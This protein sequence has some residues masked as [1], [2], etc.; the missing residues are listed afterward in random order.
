MPGGRFPLPSVLDWNRWQFEP[1][2][3]VGLL[4]L[5][6]AYVLAATRYRARLL[7]LGGPPPRW[8]PPG[9]LGPERPGA[10]S[11]WQ[12]AAFFTATLVTALALLSPL[13]VLG[14]RYLLSAHMVQHLLLT[15]VVPPLWLMG[16]PGWMLRPL[17]RIRFVRRA[18]ASLLTPLPAFFLF[19]AVFLVWH[20]PPFYELALA[21]EPVHVLEH[22]SFLALGLLTWWPVVGPLPEFP[23]LPYG[24]QVLYLFFESLPPT[25]LGALISLAEIP[26]YPTY[27]SAP[28]ITPLSPL[29]DQQLGG[30]IM[31]LPGALAYFVA[32]SIVFFLWLERQEAAREAPYGRTNPNRA[33]REHGSNQAAIR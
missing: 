28:R 31:W 29:E 33:K 13:H 4:A 1:G 9:S 8:H 32:L 17:L 12:A 6:A 20:A 5:T 3:I 7:A 15:L 10:L 30:L 18:G 25:I 26:L 23:R 2:V 16:T 14:E 11:P 22:A 27:W 19:N 24:A 21:S